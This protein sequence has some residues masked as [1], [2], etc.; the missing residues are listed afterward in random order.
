[1]TTLW[2][3]IGGVG[4]VLVGI[5]KW[6]FGRL[7]KQKEKTKV[8]EAKTEAERKEKEINQ[9]AVKVK[10]NLAIKQKEQQKAKAENN[11]KIQEASDD[12]KK[13]ESIINDIS[14]CFNDKL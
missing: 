6:L 2:A 1:M 3:I 13:Q 9:A 8:A 7:G 12:P 14:H 10:D 4:V 5:I 11:V